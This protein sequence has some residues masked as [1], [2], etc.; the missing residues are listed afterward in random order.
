MND[1]EIHTAVKQGKEL[2]EGV[3]GY[4]GIV[5]LINRSNPLSSITIEN[6]RKVLKGNTLDGI[7]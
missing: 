3:I 5:I 4:G 2:V 1:R 6:L 7:R